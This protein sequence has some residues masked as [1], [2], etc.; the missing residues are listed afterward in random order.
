MIDFLKESTFA[1]NEVLTV[2]WEDLKKYYFSIVGLCLL[3]F[4]ISALSSM[5][6]YYLNNF[7]QAFSVIMI[8]L[9][10]LT[11][12][13]LQLTLLKYI[14]HTLD[15]Q[16]GSVSLKEAIP[17]FKE[18]AD[19][20]TAGFYFLLCILFMYLLVSVAALPLVYTGLPVSMVVELAIFTATILILITWL[21]ISFFPFFIIDRQVAPFRSIRMSLAITRGNFT[22]ILIL[23][24][25][26]LQYHMVCISTLIT[27]DII[28]YQAW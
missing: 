28:S 13:I 3:I 11:Y 17:T 21:R 12:F 27:R 5:L 20:F 25:F 24:G 6:G 15:S 23:L 4:V 18:F 10:A 7:S 1:V 26:F 19:N 2:A 14:F 16:S 8:I 9:F 22:K